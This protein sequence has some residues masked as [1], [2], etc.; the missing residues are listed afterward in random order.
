LKRFDERNIVSMDPKKTQKGS[1]MMSDTSHLI[2]MMR[3]T[4]RVVMSITI[5]TATPANGG[6]HVLSIIFDERAR[7]NG[8]QDNYQSGVFTR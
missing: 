3:D 1:M 7:S 2:S 8:A 4:S 6:E 5:M